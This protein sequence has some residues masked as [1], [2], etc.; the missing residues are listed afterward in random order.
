M[1][2]LQ[3]IPS[4]NISCSGTTT[5]V[6]GW[7]LDGTRPSTTLQ[8]TAM[9]VMEDGYRLGICKKFYDQPISYLLVLGT[10]AT[11]SAT[12]PLARTK[13][14]WRTGINSIYL[15]QCTMQGVQPAK[16][17]R[18]AVRH[19]P[20]PGRALPWRL[21]LTAGADQCWGSSTG[22]TGVQWSR[23]LQGTVISCALNTVRK[24]VTDP[25]GPYYLTL[26]NSHFFTCK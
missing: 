7:G 2:L 21:G 25:V 12:A 15:Y 14:R 18:E 19:R 10:C 17:A 4:C 3:V 24:S 23:E 5:W 20:G 11:F 22:G 13:K 16:S 6:A 1:Y 26:N 8:L 9:T